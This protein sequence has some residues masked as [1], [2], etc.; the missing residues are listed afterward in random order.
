MD[1]FRQVKKK[2]IYPTITK[3]RNGKKAKAIRCVADTSCSIYFEL[4]DY[5][6]EK[7]RRQQV[8]SFCLDFDDDK[9]HLTINQNYLTSISIEAM[10]A[11]WLRQELIQ[12]I[13]YHHRKSYQ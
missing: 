12:W 2:T 6:P 7:H 5:N 11:P 3:L 10:T 1:G 13:S 4:G 8:P 9:V